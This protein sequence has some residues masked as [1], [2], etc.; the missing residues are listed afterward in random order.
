MI[1]SSDGLE[2]GCVIPH[3]PGPNGARKLNQAVV[4]FLRRQQAQNAALQ[5]IEMVEQHAFVRS[6]AVRF[7][8]WP[9]LVDDIP[10]QVSIE[11][12]NGTDR[13]GFQV[14]LR[15]PVMMITRRTAH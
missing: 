5:P 13:C 3:R 12:M 15:P 2:A 1:F 10:Q 14:D 4:E 7:A 8:P 11:Y 6:M 9:E